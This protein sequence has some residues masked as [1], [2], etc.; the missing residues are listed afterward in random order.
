MLRT[1]WCSLLENWDNGN[2]S[3]PTQ[4]RTEEAAKVISKDICNQVA[5]ISSRVYSYLKEIPQFNSIDIYG[6]IDS[7]QYSTES[8]PRH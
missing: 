5:Y 2:W 1:V 6:N 4:Q 8:F 3:A 7:E